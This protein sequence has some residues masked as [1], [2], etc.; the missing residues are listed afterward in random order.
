[1]PS[2]CFEK[3]LAGKCMKGWATEVS[4]VWY[5]F[6]VIYLY[7]FVWN[8]NDVAVTDDELKTRTKDIFF[9]KMRGGICVVLLKSRKSYRINE[10]G[11]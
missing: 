3:C 9:I 7:C 2:K 11:S 1:M 10:M 5:F 4:F 8:S 6:N